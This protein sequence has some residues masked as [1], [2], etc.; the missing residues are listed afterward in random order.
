MKASKRAKQNKGRKLLQ[1]VL[2]Q[3]FFGITGM[4]FADGS[5]ILH[6]AERRDRYE[7]YN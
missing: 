2:Q 5:G 1:S 6:A 3:L 4:R 7:I